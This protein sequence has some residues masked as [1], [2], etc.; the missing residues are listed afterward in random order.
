MSN[1][2]Q[3]IKNRRIELGLTADQLADRLQKSRATI[4]R[5]ESTDADNMPIGILEPLA[6]ALSTTPAE[7]MGWSGG[8]VKVT[9]NLSF[10]DKSPLHALTQA[11]L[12]RPSLVQ[13][14]IIRRFEGLDAT[15]S[16]NVSKLLQASGD[17]NGFM[18]GTG[19]PFATVGKFMQGETVLTTPAEAE[20]IATYFHTN[21]VDL[22]FNLDEKDELQ[23][24]PVVPPEQQEPDVVATRILDRALKTDIAADG[25]VYT[26]LMA[27]KK[28]LGSIEQDISY[29]KLRNAINIISNAEFIS[30]VYGAMQKIRKTYLYDI[31]IDDLAPVIA[32]EIYEQD[33]ICIVSYINNKNA[34]KNLKLL[35]EQKFKLNK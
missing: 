21:V 30:N 8:A 33:Y 6:R 18:K 1:I 23:Q 14:E 4:Y 26:V 11:Y 31:D 3:N 20:R 22:F 7:L 35:L 32:K 34:I 29:K 2:G 5:Y 27:L 9:T 25:L 24:E 15:F 17:I 13:D 16:H 28:Y 19:L 10:D 12:R